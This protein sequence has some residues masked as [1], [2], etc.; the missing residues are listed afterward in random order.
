MYSRVNFTV[1]HRGIS[2]R[3]MCVNSDAESPICRPR[4]Y[5]KNILGLFITSE[6]KFMSYLFFIVKPINICIK[7]K[8]HFRHWMTAVYVKSTQSCIYRILSGLQVS[9]FSSGSFT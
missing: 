4:I 8:K 1:D 9:G 6:V 5:I 2:T 3:H 7:L